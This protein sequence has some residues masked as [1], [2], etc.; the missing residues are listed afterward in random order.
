MK[1]S[2]WAADDG[3]DNTLTETS[4]TPAPNQLAREL[5][6][7]GSLE[8]ETDAFGQ[9]TLHGSILPPEESDDCEIRLTIRRDLSSLK[10][11]DPSLQR[12]PS[13]SS[14]KRGSVCNPPSCWEVILV[15]QTQFTTAA[16]SANT[17]P[18][19]HVCCDCD[20]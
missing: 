14:G 17:T 7:R 20:E 15:L 9:L 1:I 13:N 3:P 10:V 12:M 8:A 16:A 11:D 18:S 6:T 19:G 5:L 2:V 4:D